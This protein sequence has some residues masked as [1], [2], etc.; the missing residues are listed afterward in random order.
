MKSRKHPITS[1]SGKSQKLT[2]KATSSKKGRSSATAPASFET[3][4]GKESDPTI[5]KLRSQLAAA[6]VRSDR[7]SDQSIPKGA[8]FRTRHLQRLWRA[9]KHIRDLE[10]AI[11]IAVAS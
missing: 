8:L 1:N 2:T 5:V 3:V 10:E 7:L 4:F 9:Q 6:L 11:S